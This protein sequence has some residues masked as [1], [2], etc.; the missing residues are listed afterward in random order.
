[1]KVCT[2]CG[3]EK[4]LDEFWPDR[5]KKHGRMAQC[6]DCKRQAMREYR[7]KNP[8]MNKKRYWANRDKERERHLVKKYGVTFEDYA[9]MLESQGGVCAIC[10][11]PEPE[12]KTLDV[13]HDH[14]TGEVRGLLCTSCNRMLGHSGDRPEVLEAGAKYLQSCRK[15]RRSS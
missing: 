4:P 2:K 3:Q 12:N 5:S 15:S 13:D 8:D 7:A 9:A 1:M 10:G 14:E 11:K 6:K